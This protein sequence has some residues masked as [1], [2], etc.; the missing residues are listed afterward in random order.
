MRKILKASD[1]KI[2]MPLLT[3]N[4]A[5]FRLRGKE[6]QCTS[7]VFQSM[8]KV[9]EFLKENYGNVLVFDQE[10]L[11]QPDIPTRGAEEFVLRFA[12]VGMTKEEGKKILLAGLKE[13]LE[14]SGK[15]APP[16]EL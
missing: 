5:V 15:E 1:I 6:Y 9:R 13:S 12:F 3:V 2:G 11:H 14:Q 16:P 8:A 4:S 10:N 7:R